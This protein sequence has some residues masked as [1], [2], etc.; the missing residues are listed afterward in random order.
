[1]AAFNQA[2]SEILQEME[3]QN[4][5]TKYE[6]NHLKLHVLNKH[7][8][9]LERIPK[10]ADL[11]LAA[12]EEQRKKYKEILSLKPVRTLS[13]VAPIALMSDPYPCPHTMKG[14]GPC[15][16]CPGGPGSPHPALPVP[17]HGHRK[18]RLGKL[19]PKNTVGGP[20]GDNS[21]RQQSE[22]E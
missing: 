15:S 10:N 13:G 11:Y 19:N 12:S 4:P 3:K 14:I 16:Y 17:T 18:E 5:K 6:F 1:M 8:S 2:C 7:K 22:A 9:K 20:I 21:A